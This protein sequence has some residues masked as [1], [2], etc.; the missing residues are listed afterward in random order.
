MQLRAADESYGGPTWSTY[1]MY[2]HT[3]D[4]RTEQVASWKAVPGKTMKLS[5]A[6]AAD[7]DDIANVEVRTAAG[8]TVL[9]LT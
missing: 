3:T 9:E 7:V 8:E 1:T 5:A 6:T 4:G 2:V